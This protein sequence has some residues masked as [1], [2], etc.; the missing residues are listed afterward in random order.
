MLYSKMIQLYIYVH[1]HTYFIY[2]YIHTHTHIWGF[3]GGSVVKHLPASA[4]DWSLIP[5]WEDP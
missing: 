5:G 1:T 2:I 3:P 4:G